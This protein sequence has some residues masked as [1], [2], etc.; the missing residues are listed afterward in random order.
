[1]SLTATETEREREGEREGGKE[2]EGGRERGREGGRE[3]GRERGREGEREGGKERESNGLSNILN[4]LTDMHSRN[5]KT[6]ALLPRDLPI[7]T[8][9]GPTRKPQYRGGPLLP[10]DLPNATL[11]LKEASI[12]RRS[13]SPYPLQEGAPR[14]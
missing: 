8:L 13:R 3:G 10:R 4:G 6:L 12:Q 2:R 1:M 7:A 14:H 9:Y 5:D 11:P